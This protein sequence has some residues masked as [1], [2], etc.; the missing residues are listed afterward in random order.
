MP[1]QKVPS[2]ETVVT[3]TQAERLISFALSELTIENAHHEF[4]HLCRHLTRARICSNIVPATGPVSGGG[5]QGID[6]ETYPVSTSLAGTAFFALATSERWIFACSLENNTK[7]KVKEDLKAASTQVPKPEKVYFFTHKP[8]KISDKNKLRDFARTTYEIGLEMMDGKAISELLASPETVWIAERYLSLPSA[9]ILERPTSA[10]RWYQY[11]LD[12]DDAFPLTDGLFFELKDAIR[13]VAYA[14]ES[15]TDALKLF[16]K[17]RRYRSGTVDRIRRKAIYEEFVASLRGLGD[18]VGYEDDLRGYLSSLTTLTDPA[19]IEDAAVIIGYIIGARIQEGLEISLSEVEQW[20]T[21]LFQRVTTLL[22]NTEHAP[23]K[24]VLMIAQAS[25]QLSKG[26]ILASSHFEE[27]EQHIRTAAGEAISTWSE[28][29]T[30]SKEA[31]LFPVERIATFADSIA[32]LL[33]EVVGNAKFQKE[34]EAVLSQRSGKQASIQRRLRR[35]N[36]FL[37]AGMRIRALDELHQAQLDAISPN[38]AVLFTLFLARTYSN[39]GLHFAAKHYALSSAYAALKLPEEHL[40]SMAYAG[41][42]EAASADYASGGSLMFFLT[43]ETFMLLT[44][45]YSMSGPEDKRKFEWARI[46]YHLV[47]VTYWFRLISKELQSEFIARLDRWSSKDVYES[48]LP[49]AEQNF[50]GIDNLND[51]EKRTTPENICPFFSD[52]GPTRQ[53][54]WTQ[55]QI[56][57]KISWPN[58]YRV[59]RFAESFCAYLQI[60]LVELADLEL[61]IFPGT[62][63]FRSKSAPRT[64]SNSRNVADN[65]SVSRILRIPPF[66]ADHESETRLAVAA[67]FMFLDAFS[68]E[69]QEKLTEVLK[70]RLD[71]RVPK[72]FSAYASN[73]RLFEEF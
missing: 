52:A 13:E 65:H 27:R 57:W 30:V 56:I 43:A 9:F 21:Q 17:I 62:A 69:K 42:A 34:L 67:V 55:L 66:G 73:S 40:R 61:T 58:Q 72:I 44:A 70:S 29:I 14:P 5:D 11:L 28:I 32:V 64:S 51:L 18:S 20:Q 49:L 2:G 46:D 12:L 31:S 6:F 4:E 26:L 25:L 19:D 16:S 24:C 60:I 63:T 38:D 10:E 53:V 23:R 3:P 45:N 37:S 35:A 47:Q 50:S 54:T 39:L 33:E 68:A 22:A 8:I 41:C 7:K 48:A 1:P 15:R 59:A 71:E 36:T